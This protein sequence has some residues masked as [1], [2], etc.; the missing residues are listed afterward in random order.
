[1]NELSADRKVKESLLVEV[2]LG[3]DLK[4]GRE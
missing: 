3:R 2:S 1:M 4:E